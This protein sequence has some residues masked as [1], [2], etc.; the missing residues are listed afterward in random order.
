M[1]TTRMSFSY[2]Q[3]MK[4]KL[5]LLAERD[6]R[7]LS[8]YVQKILAAHLEKNP[9]EEDKKPTKL[10]KVTRRTRIKKTKKV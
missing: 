9:I 8:S 6:C 7:S 3:K 4:D 10:K 1:T 5:Q 2:P